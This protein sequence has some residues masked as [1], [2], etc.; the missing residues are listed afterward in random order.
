MVLEELLHAFRV[1]AAHVVENCGGLEVQLGAEKF[2]DGLSLVG[3]GEADPERVGAHL[4]GLGIHG[5][6]RVRGGEGDDGDLLLFADGNDGD[7]AAAEV[8]SRDDLDFVLEDQTSCGVHRIFL[9]TAE[10]VDHQFDGASQ[11]ASRGVDLFHG[12]DGHVSMVLSPGC[13]GS[14]ELN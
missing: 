7:L 4:T 10:V 12:D 11:K 14:R 1:V 9:A 8:G 2:R 5:D 13:A 3:I 6:R